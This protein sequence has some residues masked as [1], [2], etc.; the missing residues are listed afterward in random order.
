MAGNN[1]GVV[2]TTRRYPTNRDRQRAYRQRSREKQK[3]A[4][5]DPN[6]WEPG[7]PIVTVE[8][9]MNYLDEFKQNDIIRPCPECHY[10]TYYL[11]AYCR[12]CARA[13]EDYEAQ[14]RFWEYFSR[15]QRFRPIIEKEEQEAQE[16]LKG[17]R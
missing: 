2:K 15:L 4:L 8:D 3:A 5:K 7:K 9:A 11:F 6:T 13:F 12:H 10:Y 14:N 16:M 17:A 1:D